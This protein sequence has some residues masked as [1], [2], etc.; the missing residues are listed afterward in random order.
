MSIE[1]LKDG[2]SP[3]LNKSIREKSIEYFILQKCCRMN[4]GHPYYINEKNKTKGSRMGNEKR[5]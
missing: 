2:P 1:T 3:N 4:S 5:I